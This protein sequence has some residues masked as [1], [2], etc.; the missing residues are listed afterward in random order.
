MADYQLTA[1]D[2]VIR[3]A[4][5][6]YIPNDPANRDWQEYQD[7]LAAGG[8]P[9]PVK[10]PINPQLDTKPAKTAAEILGAT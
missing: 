9:D 5:G 4:D 7:W 3:T 6:A 8:V 2:I 1:T 10:P